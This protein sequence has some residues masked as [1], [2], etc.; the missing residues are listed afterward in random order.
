VSD[1][2]RAWLE[3][4]D[5]A[6]GYPDDSAGAWWRDRECDA[7]GDP[8][9]ADA[10]VDENDI[11]RCGSCIAERPQSVLGANRMVEP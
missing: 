2:L 11:A 5:P 6:P 4:G 8:L 10:Q 3:H 7:C 9:F 1:A